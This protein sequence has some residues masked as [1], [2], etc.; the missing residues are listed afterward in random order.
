MVSYAE[1]IGHN[2]QRRIHGAAGGKEAAV[3]Y[4]KI[5]EVV[6]LAIFV[7]GGGLGIAAETDGAVLVGDAG[8]RNAFPDKQAA[9]EQPLMAFMPVNRAL[10]LCLHQFFEFGDQ[11]LVAFLIIRLVGKGDASVPVHGDAIVRV[12]RMLNGTRTR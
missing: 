9:C 7:E 12:R 8:E 1:R 6:R 2:C 4:I 5:V 11:P 3:D 10:G